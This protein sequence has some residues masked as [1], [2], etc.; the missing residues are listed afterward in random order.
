MYQ[1][2]LDDI[3]S[4]TL[5]APAERKPYYQTE[6]AFIYLTCGEYESAK[7]PAEAALAALPDN[8]DALR[9][10]GV[11]C[12]E[13]GDKVRAL[14]CLKKAKALGD[15]NVDTLIAKYQ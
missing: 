3:Q 6:E 8:V 5:S 9:V 14:E 10:L 13:T 2:A 4:A 15:I 12:G 7:A 1:Q 11:A